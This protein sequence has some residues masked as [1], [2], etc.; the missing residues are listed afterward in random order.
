MTGREQFVHGLGA[1]AP[2]QRVM[3]VRIEFLRGEA[4]RLVQRQMQPVERPAGVLETIEL[5]QERRRKLRPAD[6][7]LERL[8]HVHGRGDELPRPHGAAV[9]QRDAGRLATLDDDAVE[10]DL[11]GEA[12]AGGDEGL[13]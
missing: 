6:V 5:V 7:F 3:Q 8:V 13:E 10:F 12:P 9:F 4:H 1:E 2:F 11:G